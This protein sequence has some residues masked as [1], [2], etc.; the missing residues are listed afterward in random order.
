MS[1]T[2]KA[3]KKA[4][5]LAMLGDV[6][7]DPA[8]TYTFVIN[9]DLP[10]FRAAPNLAAITLSRVTGAPV[11][12]L[13]AA[14]KEVAVADYA[15][16]DA[17]QRERL[18]LGAS[19]GRKGREVPLTKSQE[20]MVTLLKRPEGATRDELCKAAGKKLSPWAVTQKLAQRLGLQAKRDRNATPETYWLREATEG[21]APAA[22]AEPKPARGK[23]G[24][25]AG[26]A[27]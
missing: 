11:K 8:Q 3:A 22:K 18:L 25:Q 1:S 5:S 20:A 16:L 6:R 21:Q 7:L 9:A 26:A 12:V 24:Q 23:A 13:D 2:S 14:G 15:T 4:L 10:A 19:A 27:G 17:Q